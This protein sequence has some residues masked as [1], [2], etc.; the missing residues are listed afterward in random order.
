MERNPA[1]GIPAKQKL[2][3]YLRNNFYVSTS[4]NFCTPSLMNTIQW[5]GVD[6]VLFSVDYPFERMQDAANWF[7]G[8][9]M[10]SESDWNKIGR[11]NAERL[12]K[13]GGQGS[14]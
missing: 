6:R 11:L 13:L 1:K 4:G 7:D 9:D 8:T 10:V 12:M 2:D 5:M 14:K 3:Y